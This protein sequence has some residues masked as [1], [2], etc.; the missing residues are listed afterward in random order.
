[1]SASSQSLRFIL[2]LSLYSSFITSRHV[3][4]VLLLIQ[5]LVFLVK[6]LYIELLDGEC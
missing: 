4:F 5:S 6:L 3:D 2:S 1:M